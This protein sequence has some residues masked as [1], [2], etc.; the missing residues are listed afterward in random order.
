MHREYIGATSGV[1]Q[2]VRNGHLALHCGVVRFE[3]DDFDHLLVGHELYEAA[4]MR[5]RVRRRLAGADRLG[6]S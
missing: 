2:A 5:V 4:V 1:G 3:L 6:V